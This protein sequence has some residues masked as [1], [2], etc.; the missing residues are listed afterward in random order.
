MAEQRAE[1]SGRVTIRTVAEDAGVSVAAVSKVLRNAY[2][3]SDQLR[4]KVTG[5]I[6][7]LGYRPSTAA[8][9][10]RG[11]TYCIGVLLVEMN[12][13]FLPSV[14]EGVKDV[15]SAES[16]RAMI[17]VGEAQAA[18]ESSL[19]D[20]MID[21]RMDGVLLVAPRLSGEML[22]DYARRIPMTVIGHHEPEAG[23][24]DTVNSDDTAGARMAVQELI[25]AGHRD[26]HM[27]SVVPREAGHDVFGAREAGYLDAMAAAGLSDRARIWHCRETD[28]RP[29]LALTDT[30]LVADPMPTAVFCWSDIHAVPLVNLARTRGI[31]VPRQMSII[32][33]DDTPTARMPLI[34]LSSV[35]Q[36]GREIGRMA[37]RALLD[38]IGGRTEAQHLMIEPTLRL[39][40]T[41]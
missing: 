27:T 1:N 37:A 24:F 28:D 26:I 14:V 41:S 38:R 5:S 33:Y 34:G 20:S 21:L 10:M 12:N 18:I 8:R 4:S 40:G 2:G 19:I 36:H 35:D 30:V 32:G 13:P 16:Y 11:R 9:G 23:A 29:G 6:E 17:G 25:R 22:A 39:R 31:E 7:K 15:L 3:V